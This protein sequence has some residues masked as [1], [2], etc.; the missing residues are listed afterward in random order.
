[1]YNTHIY[2]FL[3]G[4]TIKKL[5]EVQVLHSQVFL[6][7]TTVLFQMKK[8]GHENQSWALAHFFDVRYPLPTQFFSLDR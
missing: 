7:A 5:N 6:K 4:L 1:M 8:R 2:A 3:L